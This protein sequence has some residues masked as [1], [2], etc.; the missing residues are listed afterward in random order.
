MGDARLLALAIATARAAGRV[1][2]QFDHMASHIAAGHVN[3]SK[4]RSLASTR[5]VAAGSR[6]DNP[7]G[8]GTSVVAAHWLVRTS[9]RRLLVRTA[10][11]YRSSLML[12]E[13]NAPNTLAGSLARSVAVTSLLAVVAAGAIIIAMPRT[14]SAQGPLI[15]QNTVPAQK[16]PSETRGQASP[17]GPARS[18]PS[19]G[20][21]PRRAR[22]ATRLPECN[23]R[24]KARAR[25][26]T[27]GPRKNP[28]PRNDWRGSAGNPLIVAQRHTLPGG[29][30]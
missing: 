23:R 30:L 10:A 2:A 26:S 19:R 17:Q 18:T 24:R 22:K 6:C 5:E 14:V 20:V 4:S 16:S 15:A 25:R 13:R 8:R 9:A 1:S 21:L 11:I 12:Q 27:P 29:L 3:S 28:T 7:A